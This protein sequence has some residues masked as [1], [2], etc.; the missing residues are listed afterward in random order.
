MFPVQRWSWQCWL[1]L[2]SMPSERAREKCTFHT[3]YISREQ[4]VFFCF[5][6]FCL[7]VHISSFLCLRSVRQVG[8]LIRWI[9]VNLWDQLQF[10]RPRLRVLIKYFLL[11]LLLI[12]SWQLGD[13]TLIKI[14]IQL[15][16]NEIQFKDRLIAFCLRSLWKF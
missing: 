14:K 9:S 6:L 13:E 8:Y 16:Q 11:Y 1:D 3:N 4:S 7:K 15:I 5:E 2:R 12:K 10:T